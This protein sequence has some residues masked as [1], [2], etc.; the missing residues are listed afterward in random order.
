MFQHKVAQQL[1]SNFWIPVRALFCQIGVFEAISVGKSPVL[2][3]DPR[4][5]VPAAVGAFVAA[6]E[7]AAQPAD[8]GVALPELVGL[9]VEPRRALGL[10]ATSS[11]NGAH[12]RM[13]TSGQPQKVQSG[14]TMSSAAS[15][16]QYMKRGGASDWS[17]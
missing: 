8:V 17:G 1:I 10:A 14:K 2:I 12:G 16:V 3:E 11:R 7:V 15:S 4:V 6:H 9:P 13:F 5:P